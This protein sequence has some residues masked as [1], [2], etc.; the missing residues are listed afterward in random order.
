[1]LIGIVII[2]W[3]FVTGLPF[4]G[5]RRDGQRQ[6][7]R[8]VETVTEAP[9]PAPS[10]TIVEVPATVGDTATSKTKSSPPQAAIDVP[11]T[12]VRKTQTAKAPRAAPVVTSRVERSEISGAEAE[13]ALREYVVS[14][15]YYRLAADCVR[16]D[17]RGYENVG[18]TLDVWDRCNEGGGSRMLGRWRVDAKTREIFR[19]RA[20]GRYLRP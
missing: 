4:G 1:M 15:N 7:P 5:D 18:Y 12:I 19:Q 17:N 13:A 6:Q 10:A 2:A 8:R 14:T 3:L 11:A 20:D 16:V 9:P